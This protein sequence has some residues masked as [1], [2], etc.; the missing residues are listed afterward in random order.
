MEQTLEFIKTNEKRFLDELFDLLRIPSLS[1]DSK[2]QKDMIRTA[3]FI[4]EKLIEF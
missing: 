2:H 4:K 3:E 1:A